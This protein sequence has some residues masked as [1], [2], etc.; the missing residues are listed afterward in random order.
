MS[1]HFYTVSFEREEEN[2]KHT[3]LLLTP[4]IV[5]WT[6]ILAIGTPVAFFFLCFFFFCFFFS[7]KFDKI[8]EWNSYLRVQRPLGFLLSKSQGEPCT[9]FWKKS[10]LSKAMSKYPDLCLSCLVNTYASRPF[11]LKDI[12]PQKLSVP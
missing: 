8:T 6:P 5:S 10:V 3:R 7:E 2:N 1:Q 9:C 12:R 4:N 11:S